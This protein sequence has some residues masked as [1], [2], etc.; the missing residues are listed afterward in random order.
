MWSK[1]ADW[2]IPSARRRRTA[3]SAAAPISTSST[4]IAV[5]TDS[6]LYFDSF[7]RDDSGTVGSPDQPSG[8]GAW[9][10]EQ[11]SS[12]ISSNALFMGA[13]A[14]ATFVHRPNTET[15]AEIFGQHVGEWHG[16]DDTP[17]IV[18]YFDTDAF[19]SRSGFQ[20]RADDFANELN[21]DQQGP[22]A[23]IA[24]T[25]FT[26]AEDFPYVH[27][28]FVADSLQEAAIWRDGVPLS[29]QT[30]DATDATHDGVD[31]RVSLQIAGDATIT[32]EWFQSWAASSRTIA[33]HGLSNGYGV[34]VK[35]ADGTVHSVATAAGSA[36]SMDISRFHEQLEEDDIWPVSG[37]SLIIQDDMSSHLTTLRGDEHPSGNIWPGVYTLTEP[38]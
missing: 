32:A 20:Q 3:A 17:I 30:V 11:G 25:G 35:H 19:A 16:G 2:L 28:F 31:K 23:N 9:V 5:T 34:F 26:S 36:V 22:F 14:T 27:E 7:N 4:T 33:V 12:E 29:I 38:S 8:A 1:P 21:I 37:L 13:N 24:N 10:E 15:E 18:G 6:L